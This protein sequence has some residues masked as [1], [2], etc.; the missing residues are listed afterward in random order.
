MSETSR[1][2]ILIIADNPRDR[3]LFRMILERAGYGVA[4]ASSGK[5][6]L[7]A[8][9][10]RRVELIILDPSTPE[11]EEFE[12]LRAAKYMPNPKIMVVAGLAPAVSERVL[13]AARKVAATATVHKS[14]AQD[15]L[16][17]MVRELLSGQ[18]SAL[19]SRTAV[20]PATQGKP[21]LVMT[22]W[23]K[24]EPMAYECSRCGQVFLLPE[25]RRP[26][27]A[28]A[29]LWAAFNDHVRE[30]HAEDVGG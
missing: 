30:V 10:N 24:G 28:V 1:P 29:E 5:E 15:L 27:D 8:I 2:V 23:A 11:M 12:V 20:Q 7:D 9:M 22:G 16:V 17:P 4:E 21:R 18:G 13:E 26:R 14:Q 19:P 6:A 25:D 3:E